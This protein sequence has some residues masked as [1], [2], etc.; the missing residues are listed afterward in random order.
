MGASAKLAWSLARLRAMGPAEVAWR[1]AGQARTVWEARRAGREGFR[2]LSTPRGAELRAALAR[3]LAPLVPPVGWAG[4]LAEG[5]PAAHA[6]LRDGA[7]AALAG[8]VVLFAREYEVG[9]P[10]DWHA[11]PG[12]GRS[13]SRSRAVS[14]DHRDGAR[15]GSVRRIWELN[16]HHHLAEVALWTWVARDRDAGRFVVEQLLDWCE[17]NPPLVG[18]NWTSSLELAIRTLAWAEILALLVDAGEPALT[19]PVLES[20]VGA[21]ARQVEHVR[22]HDSRYS[23][24]NN[25]R[26]GEAAGVA[27]AGLALPFHPRAGQW[28]QWGL[29][30][31]E[32]ELLAQIAPDGS[33]REQAFAYQRF[34]LDFAVLVCVLARG[35][36]CDLDSAAHARLRGAA[37]FLAAMTR[38]DGQLFAVGDDDE[39]RAFALGEAF[40]ERT[41]ASLECLGWLYGE[42]AWRRG[43]YPRAR[44]LGL[45]RE[46]A[47]AAAGPDFPEVPGPAPG[48]LAATEPLAIGTYPQ[49]GYALVSAA[50]EDASLRLLFDA[51][52]LGYGTLAA[53]GH[54]DALSLWLWAGEDLLVDSGTGSYGGDPEWREA[55]R[56]TQAHNTCEV[57]GRDQSKRCGPFL[58]GRKA[59]AR[60]LAA[61]CGAPYFVVAGRHDG[62][63][64]RGVAE[65]RRTVAGCMFP[66][67]VALVV[68]DEALGTGK[69]RWRVPWHLGAGEPTLL[70]EERG[71]LWEVHYPGGARLRAL[72][73]SL[74][75]AGPGGLRAETARG[76][77]WPDGAWYAPRFEERAAQGRIA[78]TAAVALPAAVVWLLHASWAGRGGSPVAA[79]ELAAHPADGGVALACELG[80]GYRL[81]ALVAHPGAAAV[82]SGEA[83]MHGRLGLWLAGE[84][85]GGGET[86]A[87]VA[88]ATR[89][90]T[91]TMAW[92]SEPAVTGVLPRDSRR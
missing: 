49:G 28:R 76:G 70:D 84:P 14:L 45:A 42:P 62:Y 9:V 21:W 17:A 63:A 57:D 8:R 12:S 25:H 44:W 5:F 83:E 85:E 11:D 82:A 60:L 61:D 34:V 50:G 19:D 72:V 13:A 27:V 55:L 18:V 64:R 6:R 67:G 10:A 80:G 33:G 1:V 54:A 90:Q 53:H 75:A 47:A 7:R 92:S 40:E 77:S 66:R 38:P 37:R 31:L 39:G 36:G 51:G 30:T 46:P 73:V 88:G 48:P 71:P 59:R 3:G 65:V 20:L 79:A 52:P 74:P 32:E 86:G 23:S 41:H 24:A 16:R 43:A 2:A 87:V 69:H 68:V 81:R 15:V 91:E 22:A 56:G 89:L 35:H 78:A 4:R 26:I 58:W 29:R